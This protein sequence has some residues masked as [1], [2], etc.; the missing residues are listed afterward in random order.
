MTSLDVASRVVSPDQTFLPGF[1]ELLA[2]PIV[3]IRIEAFATAQRRDTLFAP[4]ALEDDPD[5]L[6][7]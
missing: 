7:G 4:Q 6:F 2:P 3:E 5:L 1:E